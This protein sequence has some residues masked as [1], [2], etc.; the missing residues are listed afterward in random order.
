M[1]RVYIEFNNISSYGYIIKKVDFGLYLIFIESI[2]K[3]VEIEDKYIKGLEIA[4]R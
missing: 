3:S 2:G 1:R 4:F